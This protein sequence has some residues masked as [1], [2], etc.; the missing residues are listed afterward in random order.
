MWS[1]TN[2]ELHGGVRSNDQ[3]RRLGDTVILLVGHQTCRFESCLGTIVQS[4]YWQ[5][6]GGKPPLQL[7]PYG[8]IECVYYF[9]FNFFVPLAVKIPRVKRYK[10]S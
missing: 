10:T 2:K 6:L 7:R 9:F 5:K 1:G 8:G 3:T 4:P